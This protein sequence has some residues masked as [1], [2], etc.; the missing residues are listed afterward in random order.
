MYHVT[1]IFLKGYN[2]QGDK[3]G[4]PSTADEILSDWVQGGLINRASHLPADVTNLPWQGQ[5][6][7]EVSPSHQHLEGIQ[8]H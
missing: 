2:G 1:K 6:E 3:I 7:Q 4:Y 5:D 8:H